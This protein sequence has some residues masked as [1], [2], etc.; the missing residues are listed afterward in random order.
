MLMPQAFGVLGMNQALQISGLPLLKSHTVIV[1]RGLIVV[2]TTSIWPK[3]GDVLRRQI[4]Q[5]SK[6]PFALPDLLLGALAVMDVRS[7]GIPAREPSLLV[8]QGVMAN[9]EPAVLT[10]LQPHA[11][12][13]IERHTACERPGAFVPHSVNV[14]GVIEARAKV[15][16]HHVG[17]R[18]AR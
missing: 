3:F 10:I 1:E 18:N 9:Q 13:S 2:Q 8:V 4:Q 6:L 16:C 11:L 15:R 17:H 12:L 7:G 14:I 5:L